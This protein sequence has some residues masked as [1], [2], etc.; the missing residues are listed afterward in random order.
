M[1]TTGIPPPI[2]FWRATA[3]YSVKSFVTIKDFSINK[4]IEKNL[5]KLAV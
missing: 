2:E 4:E 1:F 3:L 5:Y